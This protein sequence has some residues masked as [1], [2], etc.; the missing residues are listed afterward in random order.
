MFTGYMFTYVAP[1]VFVLLM[2][3]MKE[4]YDDFMR[5]TRDKELNQ[6]VYPVLNAQADYTPV[7]SQDL[8]VGMIMKIS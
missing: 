7:M 1:L 4:F 3:M 2:T 8:K 6:F 5:Y